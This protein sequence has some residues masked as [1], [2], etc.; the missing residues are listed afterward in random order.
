MRHRPDLSVSGEEKY[1]F[2]P[3][4][5]ENRSVQTVT[6]KYNYKS[7]Q[8]LTAGVAPV[9]VFSALTQYRIIPY[10]A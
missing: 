10:R 1:L 2:S 8:V 3:S 9:I 4:G 6:Q 5:F 7:F